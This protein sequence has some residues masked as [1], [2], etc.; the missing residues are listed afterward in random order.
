MARPERGRRRRRHRALR[1]P[2][3]LGDGGAGPAPGVPGRPGDPGLPHA[4]EDGRRDASSGASG[5]HGA[6]GPDLGGTPGDGGPRAPRRSPVALRR[7]RRDLVRQAARHPPRGGRRPRGSRPHLRGGACLGD[8][9]GGAE[10]RARRTQGPAVGGLRRRPAAGRRR[11]VH[12]H[13]RA[14]AGLR[15]GPARPEG[16]SP[17]AAARPR[18]GGPLRPVRS[19]RRLAAP[20]AVSTGKGHRRR[21]RWPLLCVVFGCARRQRVRRR[22]LASTTPAAMSRGSSPLAAIGRELAPVNGI[23]PPPELGAPAVVV[24]V[25]PAAVVVVVP[26]VVVVVVPPVVVVVVPPVVVVVVVPVLPQPV[27]QNTLYLVSAPCDPSAWMV[28]LTWT[29]CS[30]CGS[31]PVRS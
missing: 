31:M 16:R 23:T 21:A 11:P 14:A 10:L 28:S 15:R 26:P 1:L 3:R 13:H 20:K 5:D 6:H 19:V 9:G 24:V 7:R 18:T 12:R 27:T 30:G 8:L 29:P 22:R 2:D 25:A 17:V 4:G